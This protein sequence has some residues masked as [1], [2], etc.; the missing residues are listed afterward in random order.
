M[1]SRCLTTLL[2]GGITFYQK[3]ISPWLPARCRYYPTCS[4]YARQAIL[5]HGV[6]Q[7]LLLLLGRLLR[8]QP[9]GASGIDCVPVPLRRYHY[10]PTTC[11]WSCVLKDRFGYA[12]R[13]N[14]LMKN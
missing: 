13:L 14:H 6:Y 7:G 4:Q 5:W 11:L 3:A 10:C 8:C 12:A 2:L 1:C 9:F